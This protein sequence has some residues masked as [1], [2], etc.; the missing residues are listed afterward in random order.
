MRITLVSLFSFLLCYYCI[1]LTFQI[2][3]ASA[4]CLE[5]QQSLLLQL[6]N[7]L[8]Y[9]PE[10]STKLKLWNKSTACC[11]WNG[12]SCDSKGHVIGLDFIA[13]DI[14]DG[15]DN[16]S[17][18]FS[19]HHL[20][21][22]NL[23]DNN[24]NSVIP[25]GFNKL[26][27]LNYLN[28][29]YANFVGHISIEISQLTRLVTLDLSSQS[30]YV[31]IK[32]GLKF[33]NT[34]LQK[35]VQ[36]LTSLRKLYL[37]GVSLKAQGQEWSDA[38]FPLRNLQVLSMS[39]CDLSGP[40]SSSL[41]RLKNLSVI[42]LDGNYFSS[43]VPET[44]SNFKK[45]TT[46]S[47]SSCGLTG[48][49]PQNIFQIGTLSFIDLSFNYNLH[50]SFPEFPLSGSLHTLRVSN[51]SFS[52]AFPYSIGNMRHLSELDLLNCKFNGTL[53]NSLSNLTELRCIDLSSNNFA[54]PMPS[55]G[56]SKYLIHL[57]LSHNR[58]SGEIPKSSHFEGLHSLVSIDLRDNSINGSIPSSLFALPSLLEI[59]LSSNRFSKFDEFKNMSSSVINTLDLSS[60]NLSGPFPTSIFQFRSLYV[61]DLSINRLN[62]WVQ[63]DELL[64]LSSLTALDLSYNNISINVNVENADHTSFSNISTLKLA[65]CNLKT[66]PSFLR[67]KSRLSI[68]DLSHNQIQGIVPNW[69]WRIQNLQSLNVSHNMLTD[70]EGP[71]QNLTSNLIAL[72]IHNN[73]LEGPIPVFPEFASYLDYSMN[74]FD[75]VIPQDI[76]N[77]LSFTTFLSFSNNTLHGTIPQSLCNASNLQVLDISINSISG[78]IPSCLMSMT[79]TLV[80]LNLKMNNLTGTIPDAFPPYCVLRTL[81]LQKNNLDGQIPKS[82]VKCSA[83]EV[84]NLAN[85]IIIGTFPCLLKNISTIRVIVLRSN[86]FNGHIGCPNT[87]GTWQMLQIVDLA[88]NN[89][90]GK[91]PG[92][93]FTTWEAMRSDENQADLKVKRVQFE[94]LQ[95]GQIYYHDS[96]TVT[97][98]G[99]QM[100]L[101][102]ILTVFTSIDFSSNHFEGPIPYSIGNFKA[103]YI[104]NISNNRL[105]GKIPSSIGNLKQLES[106]DLSNNTL[107]GEIPVQL[108]SLSFLSYLNLS[109]NH[110]VGKIP[111]GT[112]LQSFQSSSFEGNDGLYGPPLTEKPDG[113]RND[114]L[115]SCSTDW[116]FLSV[117]L[118]FVFGLGIVIG[119]LMFWKQWRIRY[120]K[121][122]DKIL[123]WIF[124]R[125]HLE[126]V[127]HRGQTYIVL[128]WH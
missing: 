8:T 48:T 89:F 7:N 71:L 95:F 99:Q 85:N 68:L 58:L 9:N 115:L 46:L 108:E 104:L 122:V 50:G 15:F 45:L 2:T 62:G 41:T 61:L 92:K 84:L 96:V 32:K 100:D 53:P 105:S 1:Y 87:S 6:K 103:L 118:G 31:C 83:L 43:L 80:V 124:S 37:D 34:N 102:K 119:P 16:S 44:F 101:V 117:E 79:Q 91:L 73:Q 67:N 13:E 28:L 72:D 20:Q 56:M 4:K 81:D 77:Y 29:S 11:Y 38:L 69:I 24:F 65:S 75:S 19:L 40:L 94:V 33:E 55:F 70:L 114:E 126:Y 36:N 17:S 35:F 88:F 59:Q 78:T 18:L 127:T 98:K 30:N 112:Q 14:S 51:T 10:T 107:T 123:C 60:N 120:W 113:K 121:L 3:V 106:L 42:I 25:S 54:G 109:F 110:L 86:K 12:V 26:V 125:I 116:K 27:M 90:S 63:L 21:K 64:E 76:G 93:F 39:Y 5:D 49:F 66:F 23:A 52:G 47:L 22:L 97:S 111:T 82:L 128:R 57:D 74:K